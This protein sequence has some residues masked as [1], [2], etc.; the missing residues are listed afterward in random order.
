MIRAILALLAMADLASSCA[1]QMRRSD[2]AD[3]RLREVRAAFEQHT[4]AMLREA[5]D[6]SLSTLLAERISAFVSDD[7]GPY[8]ARVTCID[9][10]MAFPPPR[11]WRDTARFASRDYAYA[12]H[13]QVRYYDL[14]KQGHSSG[15]VYEALFEERDALMAQNEG[16]ISN[17]TGEDD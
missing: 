8:V 15:E 5:R 9:I 7:E 10:D 13:W 12:Q 14:C 3:E 2:A 11:R 1:S 6:P 17:E 4:V 16:L